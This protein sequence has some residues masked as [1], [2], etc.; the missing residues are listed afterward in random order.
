MAR[1]FKDSR[2]AFEG[3]WLPMIVLW[4]CVVWCGLEIV[5]VLKTIAELVVNHGV[6]TSKEAT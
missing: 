1:P 5:V 6:T 3:L 4:F 2:F